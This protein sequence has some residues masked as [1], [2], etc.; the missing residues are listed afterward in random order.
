MPTLPSVDVIVLTYNH[1]HFI[2]QALDSVLMQSGEFKLRATIIDD[3]STDGTREVVQQYARSRPDVIRLRLHDSNLNSGRPLME[4]ILRSKADYVAILE[5]DDYWL[6]PD[7]LQKQ[8]HYLHVHRDCAI[9]YHNVYVIYEDGR[10]LTHLKNPE[11]Q[12]LRSCIHDLFVRDFIAT[13]SVIYRRTALDSIPDWYADV[14]GGDWNLHLLAAQSGFIGYIR[15][16]LGVYRV[17]SAGVWSSMSAVQ[18]W[19]YSA[20]VLCE[21]FS[22]FDATFHRDIQNG[23]VNVYQYLAHAQAAAGDLIGSLES[24]RKARIN[25]RSQWPSSPTIVDM[26][27]SKL[28]LGAGQAGEALELSIQCKTALPTSFVVFNGTPLKTEF[29]SPS[30]LCGYVPFSLLKCAGSYPVHVIDLTGESNPIRFQIFER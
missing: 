7:K 25:D 22:H 4:E 29:K 30:L 14:E 18:Q 8:I 13:C 2:K 15:E 12:P 21:M 28:I 17:H 24:L 27:P 6:R 19:Q 5:G 9:C 26:L 10:R 16:P 11:N 23:L 1:R 20:D 3:F